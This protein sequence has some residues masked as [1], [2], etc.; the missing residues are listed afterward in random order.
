[1]IRKILLALLMPF[2]YP[3]ILISSLHTRKVSDDLKYQVFQIWAKWI[4]K[5]SSTRVSLK[6]ADLIPLENGYVFISN[7]A[8]AFDPL[9]IASVLPVSTYFACDTRERVPFI[10]T[11]YKRIQTLFFSPNTS[12]YS[13]L[14]AKLEQYLSAGNLTL[15]N[16]NMK[17]ESLNEAFFEL[18]K[19]HRLTLIP[20]S[21]ANSSAI[22]KKGIHHKV[23]LTVGIPLYFEE[24]DAWANQNIQ[25]ELTLRLKQGLDLV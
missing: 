7:H 18:A 19:Q 4:V 3:V 2:V 8:N 5:M 14:D 11:W 20:L 16:T 6:R 23:T 15:F 17:G 24:Y 10:H 9:L 21:L 22:F 13:A 1:M 12:D 25:E